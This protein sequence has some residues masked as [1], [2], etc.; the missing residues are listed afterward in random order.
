MS[1]PRAPSTDFYTT[2]LR[3][4]FF[5]L[6]IYK[7]SSTGRDFANNNTANSLQK[8]I[9]QFA[10][11]RERSPTLNLGSYLDS[12]STFIDSTSCKSAI[13]NLIFQENC[14]ISFHSI[15]SKT[16][17]TCIGGLNHM[18]DQI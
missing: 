17:V 4:G 14:F 10:S 15:F 16:S 18:S 5:T 1:S 6:Q 2:K 3:L 12:I 8:N 13:N 9:T 7:I 11:S